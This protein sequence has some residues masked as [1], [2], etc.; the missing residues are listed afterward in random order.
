MDTKFKIGDIIV[1]RG[2]EGYFDTDKVQII[3][4]ISPDYIFSMFIDTGDRNM[5]HINSDYFEKCN[6]IYGEEVFVFDNG[7]PLIWEGEL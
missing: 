5:F 3:T 2:I 7:V 4:D 1:Y 6:I